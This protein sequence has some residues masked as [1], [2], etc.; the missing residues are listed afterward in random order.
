MNGL[1]NDVKGAVRQVARHPGF[2][3]L[4]ILPLALA[5]GANTALFSV[6]RGVLL[7]PLP[8]PEPDRL[9]RVLNSWNGRPIGWISPPE[10][11]DDLSRLHAFERVAAWTSGG[12]NLSG[13]EPPEHILVGIASASF[14]PVLGLA[15]QIGRWFLEEEE[16]PGRDGEIVL[17][18]ALWQRRFGGDPRVLGRAL[19]I[20]GQPVR[21]VGVLPRGVLPV[22]DFDA[23]VPLALPRDMYEPAAR[24]S[25]FL[26]VVGRLAATTGPREARAELS[27]AAN[28]ARSDH[29]ATYP[30][31]YDFTYAAIPLLDA[32]VGGMRVTL[33]ML[34]AAVALV[35]LM[36]CAN[37]GNL[38]LARATSR[39]PEL[40]IRAALGAGRGRLVRQLLLESL[41]LSLLAG[42]LGVFVA[43]W[44]I[45][46]LLALGPKD[47]PRAG[48]VRM[49]SAVLAFA[50]AA[51]VS[52]GALFGLLPALTASR[53]DLHGAMRGGAA[54]SDGRRPRR[55]RRALVVFDVALALVLLVGASLLL[56]S[57]TKVLAV[58]P[59]FR[60]EG[61]LTL[62][63]SL[64]GG[65]M[66]DGSDEERQR[67]FY[68]RAARELRAIP[69][70]EAAGAISF[71]PL[72]GVDN[73]RLFEIEGRPTPSG[74][75]RPDAQ[76]RITTPGYFEAVGMPLVL[77]R[78][79][80]PLDTA[81]APAAV[82]VNQ[83]FARRFFP[84]GDV[85]GHRIQL[86]GRWYPIVG[87]AGDVREFGLDAP[88]PPIMYFAL[89]Q[90]PR[91]TMT[92][93]LRSGRSP[94]EISRA[95]AAA[96][97]SADAQLPVYAVRP[98]GNL[99]AGSLAQRRFALTLL[100]SLAALAL[101]LAGLGLYGVLAHSVALRMREIGVRMAL[102]A[103]ARAVLSLVLR[104]SLGVVSLGL[105]IGSA[106]ALVAA[107]SIGSLLYGVGPADPA[108]LLAA[109]LVLAA[110]AVLASVFPARQATR[111]DPVIALRSE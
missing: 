24:S 9:V 70:V 12:V 97:A 59:G 47:L 63:M 23:W 101:L 102:G 1:S 107:R 67:T 53:V 10:Y 50:V 33:W 42:A 5:I 106:A 27:L 98:L 3:A 99:F 2:A 86:D 64:S 75:E 104:E 17:S 30:A 32:A 108:A 105:A 69:G 39:E 60:P 91:G 43:G 74:A 34:F 62:R 41:L 15:P 84:D 31:A 96:V 7:R 8:Y 35:L 94:S 44:G 46:L 21:I 38:V 78:A 25:H 55:L 16:Q 49:D 65:S 92:F 6:V 37:V 100:G 85:L 18:H 77:G 72:S 57:F 54:V 56:R 14:L 93:V 109:A 87:V 79:L 95:A 71:L 51:S 29:P 76:I 22:D 81:S 103:D 20:D 26:N 110:A 68:A 19:R 45:D 40:A 89:E 4:V 111:V 13:D 61:A 82:V 52:T 36:A 88:A 28:R 90:M 11:R 58:D 83:S 66:H 80:S 48:E 73:D